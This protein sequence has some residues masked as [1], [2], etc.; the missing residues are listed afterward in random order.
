MP[1][2][3]SPSPEI[4]RLCAFE[5]DGA[6]IV[7]THCGFRLDPWPGE[8]LPYANCVPPRPVAPT[9]GAGTELKKLLG[10]VGIKATPNCKCN[11]RA[12][13]MDAMGLQWCRDNIAEISGWL[14]EESASRGLPYVH[15]VGERLVKYAISRAEKDPH[16]RP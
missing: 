14:A 16:A 1:Q 8:A 7:C 11:S 9:G 6:G 10:K 4:T 5:R 2:P 3:T 12:R 15:A 13:H